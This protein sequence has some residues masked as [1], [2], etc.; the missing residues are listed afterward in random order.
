MNEV[1]TV[2]RAY[3]PRFNINLQAGNNN[4]ICLFQGA[5]ERKQTVGATKGKEEKRTREQSSSD[6]SVAVLIKNPDIFFL[7]RNNLYLGE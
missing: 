5:P 1:K 7:G 4:S 3:F 6:R 2:V